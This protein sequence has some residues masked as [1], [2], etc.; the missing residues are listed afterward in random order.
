LQKIGILVVCYGSRGVAMVDAF[1]HSEEYVVD[2]YIADKQRN[3][4][5]ARRAKQ[6]AII[7]DLNVRVICDFAANFKDEID[8]GIVDPEKPII[9]GVRDLVE[10][11]TGIP[12]ICPTKEFAIEASKVAQRRLFDA[13]APKLN[14]RYK[15]FDPKEYSSSPSRLKDDLGAWLDELDDR[16]A[17]KPDGP[18]SGKGVGVWGDHFTTREDLFAHFMSN[19]EKGTV[20]VEEKVEGEESS[21]QALCDG[22]HL[23]PLPE[24]RDYKRA[25][26]GDRGPNTGGMGS[27]KD[28]GDILPF[29]TADEREEELKTERAIFERLKGR[30][31]NPGLRGVPCYD[32]YMHTG[33]GFKV[34]ERNSRPGDPEIIS[35]LPLMKDDFVEVCLKIIEGRLKGIE[36]EKMAS[37]VTYKVP[38]TYGGYQREYVGDNLID[39]T[40]AEGL[41]KAHGSR[42]RIYPA[43]VDLRD[44]RCYALGSRAVAVFGAGESIQSAREVSLEGIRAVRGPL[45]N[46]S[47]IASEGHLRNSISHMKALKKGVSKWPL[48]P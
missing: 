13:V 25:F 17:V 44:G 33:S 1:L 6:Q 45:W 16:V 11:E 32:A 23:V 41:E 7:P 12:L 39:L 28:V 47:D 19:F 37:V 46:R 3:P 5:N 38:M 14:P 18:V 20:I 24:T 2:L 26:D 43:S 35:L 27:Y 22:R 48:R 10:G 15:V 40:G 30:G 29:M 8:F 21:F 36:F 4:F 42:I 31:S 9:D 34:L